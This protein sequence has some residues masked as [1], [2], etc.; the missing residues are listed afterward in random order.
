MKYEKSDTTIIHYN[1]FERW[2][3]VNSNDKPILGPISVTEA[4]APHR[5]KS[6]GIIEK[7]SD[8]LNSCGGTSMKLKRDYHIMEHAPYCDFH[9]YTGG[10]RNET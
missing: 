4:P 5:N 3:E 8:V 10:K 1:R 6:I 9:H 7:S 2:A